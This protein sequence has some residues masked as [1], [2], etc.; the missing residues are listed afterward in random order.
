MDVSVLKRAVEEE[1]KECCCTS[2]KEG[3][4]DSRMETKTE[5][6]EISGG[7]EGE[8]CKNS[9]GDGTDNSRRRKA[10]R[11]FVK[12]GNGQLR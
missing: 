4:K 7:L 6:G 9:D 11:Q 1:E 10:R 3:V 8:C 12:K 2:R 5:S